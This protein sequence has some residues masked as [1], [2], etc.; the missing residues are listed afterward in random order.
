M[1]RKTDAFCSS[2]E[3]DWYKMIFLRATIHVLWA[4]GRD[5]LCMCIKFKRRRLIGH[6]NI[7]RFD[8]H[9]KLKYSI[10]F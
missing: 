1:L 2:L 9:L 4:T 6:N 8:Q 3:G 10:M 7:P 5:I